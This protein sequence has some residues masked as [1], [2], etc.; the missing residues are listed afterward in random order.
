MGNDWLGATSSLASPRSKPADDLLGGAGL[1]KGT[2]KEED[3]FLGLGEE[4][5]LDSLLPKYVLLQ[6]QIHERFLSNNSP[7][8]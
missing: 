4:V 1:G 6:G 7:H 5:D 3:D 8:M 2:N